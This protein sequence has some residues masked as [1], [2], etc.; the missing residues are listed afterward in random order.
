S[1]AER[2]DYYRANIQSWINAA[3][4]QIR[5]LS[6]WEVLINRGLGLLNPDNR[7]AAESLEGLKDYFNFLSWYLSD[8]EEQYKLW[9]KGEIQDRA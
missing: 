3:S 4:G 7:A 5:K 6:A 1:G 2:K 9:K 8:F